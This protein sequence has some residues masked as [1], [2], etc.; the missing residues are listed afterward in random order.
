VDGLSGFPDAV[1][2]VF[3]KAGVQLCI[4]HIVRDSMKYVPYKDRRAVTADLKEIYLAP[5]E[6]AA[7][8]AL[9]RF[10]EKWD[11]KYPAVSKSWRSR[12]ARTIGSRDNPVH[13]IFP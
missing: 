13:E 1:N 11:R 3:P 2:A 12:W 10:A 7:G 9:E 4:V 8:A 6:D 5:S